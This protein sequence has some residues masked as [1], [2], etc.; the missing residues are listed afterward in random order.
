MGAAEAAKQAARLTDPV[1][2]GLGM[3]GML[4]GLVLG[5]I[6]GAIL[7]AATVATGGG[8]LVVALSIVSA[9][10]ITAG[11]GLAG[12]QLAHGLSTLFGCSGMVTGDIVPTCSSNVNVGGKPSARAKLDGA[13]CNGLYGLNHFDKPLALIATG[14]ANVYINGMPAARQ[15]DKLVCNA[16]IKQG[17]PTVRM[18]GGTVQVLPIHDNEAWLRDI[19]GKVALASLA[20]AA[21]L[22]GGG[23]LAGAICG[24]T[25]LEAVGV[26]VAF[27]AGNELLGKIGDSMGPGWRDTLQ[28]GFGV[29]TSIFAGASGLRAIGE[30]R[31]LIGEPI[32]GVSGEVCMW[33][34]D[35]ALPGALAVIL[36]RAYASASPHESCFG[37]RWSSTWGQWVEAATNTATWYSDDGRHIEFE[38]PSDGPSTWIR[39][40]HVNRVRLRRDN[41]GF[42]VITDSGQILRFAVRSGCRWQLS[43]IEDRNGNT[44]RFRY[45]ESATLRRVEHS[46]GYVLN[47]EATANRVH[48]IE[49]K[50]ATGPVELVRYEYDD[51]SRLAAVIDGSGLPFRYRYDTHGRVIH[52]ED[53]KGTW[54][55]YV[56]DSR[57]R[58]IQAIGP[59]RMFHYQF[60]YD[61]ATRTNIATDSTGAA[62]TFIYNQ[63]QQVVERRDAGGGVTRTEWDERSNKL[64]E[65]D[66]AGRT[67]E[68]QYDADG[69]PIF[70]RDGLGNVTQVR[71]NSFGLPDQLTDPLGNLWHRHYDEHGNLVDSWGPDGAVW[72]YERDLKGN[73]AVLTDP[74]GNS[75]RFGYDNR[76]LLIWSTDALNRRTYF[77]RDAHGRVMER[78]DALGQRTALTYNLQNQLA[79][80]VA[81]DGG[82]FLWEYD[83]EGNLSRTVAP[84]GRE[85]RYIYGV[86]D[87]LQ[88]VHK[89]SGAT[90]EFRYDTEARL[91]E[92]CNELNQ[93]WRY[94]YNPTGQVIDERDFSGRVLRFEHDPTGLCTLRV[95]GQGEAVHLSYDAASRLIRK[96][97][98]DGGETEFTY[99]PCGRLT[100]ARHNTIEVSFERDDCGRITRET[101]GGH[102]IESHYDR[103]GLRTRR[104]TGARECEWQWDCNGQ[105]STLHLP[106]KEWLEFTHDAAG[107]D[108]ERRLRG[109]LFLQQEYDQAGRLASQWAGLDAAPDAAVSRA[110]TYNESGEPEAIDDQFWGRA[111]FTYNSD[112]RI[113]TAEGGKKKPERFEYDDAG[114]NILANTELRFYTEGGRL[115]RAGQTEYT[116]DGDGRVI[117]KRVG[118]RAWSYDWTSEGRLRSLETPEG[119]YWRY[120]YDAFGRRVAK[121]GPR[122]SCEYLWDGAVVAEEVR[123]G[124]SSAWEFEPGTFRPLVKQESG[125]TF[126]CVT[127]QVGTPR[128]LLSSDGLTAWRAQSSTFG[129][130]EDIEHRTTDC[131][132]RFQGQWLDDESGLAYNFHRYYEPSTGQYLSSDP[133]GLK[134]GLRNHG[135]VH[136]PLAWVDP[137]GLVSFWSPGGAAS[138][139]YPGIGTT[140]NGGPD[141]TG[142][143]Y[144]Y[145]AT[146]D[147]QSIVSIPMQ[148]TRG[149]DFTQAFNESG[150][151]RADA[152]GYTWHHVDDFDPATGNTTM[153]LV[154][155]DAHEA[156]YT[157][158]GSVKQFSDEYGVKYDTQ[159]AVKVSESKGWLQ[160]APCK[161]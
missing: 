112:G 93:S 30:G 157:H 37:P 83:A 71:Y 138:K 94:T 35:I 99:D 131:S 12:G 144:L 113:A 118:L 146:G 120:D 5:A 33:K 26:G 80:A 57:G 74:E 107:R 142:T 116:Y 117:E 15:S 108:V 59:A 22:L 104:S 31:P 154:Q 55:D 53:R 9:V 17:W 140:P 141:F 39:H 150:I 23:F 159:D 132:I 110:F 75:R 152:D 29:G 158:E 45:D 60:A 115:E 90:L 46:G 84:G 21:L 19:L 122:G 54:Y 96:Q 11:T 1:E 4:A 92:V 85:Y 77:A 70:V 3:L 95:N 61:D 28:G 126:V 105:L 134:G 125:K 153:Q 58:C 106:G 109:G 139:G 101:Q 20:A 100:S 147:Q 143:D 161:G 49:L 50:T 79:T 103:R 78:I 36:K 151:S 129:E 137:W 38:L 65:S 25:V 135:Y 155:S 82:N 43:G 66:A 18:G 51:Q 128:E 91:I 27:F 13:A 42:A 52:W 124:K 119:E 44:I 148:G 130:A 7:V 160:G 121:H 89:P 41:S 97:S 16:D 111:R 149:R 136:N 64:K 102:R 88:K 8:A 48:R 47:V 56:Y 6:V 114:S 24:A 81:P 63:R 133:L 145:P 87:R 76:G 10:G 72:H 2:H 73:L 14:S 67:I 34:T 62:T 123:N 86:F 127:D 40:P 32:D 156:T 98:S 68:R 69:H